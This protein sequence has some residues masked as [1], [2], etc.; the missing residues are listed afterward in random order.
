MRPVGPCSLLLL[1]LLLSAGA[2]GSGV[3]VEVPLP[4]GALRHQAPPQGYVALAVPPGTPLADCWELAT[5]TEDFVSIV[6]PSSARPWYRTRAKILWDADNLYIA[7]EME[8][9]R[10]FA[11]KTLHDSII[12]H[13]ND[14]EVFL[15]PDGDNHMYYEIE[16]N[17][18]GQ[19]WDLMLVKPY[20]NGGPAVMNWE[21]VP[22]ALPTQHTGPT[23]WRP[24]SVSVRVSPEGGLNSA[25]GSTSWTVELSLPW[26][27][28]QQAA[29]RQVPPAHGDKWRINFSRVHWNVTWSEEQQRYVKEPPDQPGYNWVWSPQWQV[30][31]HQ[32]ETWG[33]VQFSTVSV[34]EAAASP[35]SFTPEA[36]WPARALL[37]DVYYA[38]TLC[39]QALK[40][41]CSSL[42]EA[43]QYADLRDITHPVEIQTTKVSFVASTE[44][45]LADGSRML[46]MVD[47]LSRL[48]QTPVG[49][50]GL[51]PHFNP[52]EGA[53]MFPP[54][55][56]TRDC[57]ASS[58]CMQQEL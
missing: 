37:M 31:M 7:A 55:T 22:P 38:Q 48:V 36:T 42:H 56:D 11:H 27:L 53:S 32:P 21:T 51:L 30:Q 25:N 47:Q 29:N 35:A 28:L 4:Y 20:R 9:P 26:S 58:S 1:F 14:F 46:V 34:E 57:K 16:V 54:E 52:F 44:V 10:A 6:G 8:E 12:Y 33:F 23:G 2:G 39:W 19:V 17:A 3:L 24:A 40:R 43:S 5:P 50:G 13:D 49:V 15:D 18:A 45:Q 41:F